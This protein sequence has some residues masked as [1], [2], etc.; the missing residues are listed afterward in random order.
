MNIDFDSKQIMSVF[1]FEIAEIAKSLIIPFVCVL[2]SIVLYVIFI[3]PYSFIEQ[4]FGSSK[5]ALESDIA[6]LEKNRAILVSS[7]EQIEPLQK[8][9]DQL[10]KYV[11][12]NPNPALVSG[13]LQDFAVQTN[14][15]LV[16]ENRNVEVDPSQ[17]QN[18]IEVR[19][20][21]RTI[22]V[23]SAVN[24]L[25]LINSTKDSLYAIR[26]LEIFR[27]QDEDF[28]RVSFLTQT[29]YDSSAAKL[30]PL[31]PLPNILD[32]EDFKKF[33]EIVVAN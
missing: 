9:S 12:P 16:E 25:N 26:N 32:R 33:R 4:T 27:N 30:D 14:F 28:T 1:K 5:A 24:F 17:G 22:G 23:T 2:A 31:S 13:I 10:V 8:V 3:S 20:N 18:I 29:I 21:G 11:S 19:F 15:T 6:I 7:R